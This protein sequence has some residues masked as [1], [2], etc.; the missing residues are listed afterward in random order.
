MAAAAAADERV[1]LLCTLAHDDLLSFQ[2]QMPPG[3]ETHN[4]V[5]SVGVSH[6]DRI[7]QAVDDAAAKH[8]AETEE[9]KNRVKVLEQEVAELKALISIP[10]A[11]LARTYQD[12]QSEV[13]SLRVQNTTLTDA[14]TQLF[15]EIRRRDA[16]NVALR[17]E[18]QRE[19][20]QGRA[21]EGD[22]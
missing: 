4:Y 2:L 7:L 19:R 14:Q 5:A 8:R 12:A 17:E 21:V 6:V 1:R 16:E 18:L 9:L 13:A 15:V 3:V 11:A 10:H 22:N 20:K